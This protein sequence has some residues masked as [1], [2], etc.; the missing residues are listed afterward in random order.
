MALYPLQ[1]KPMDCERA[2]VVLEKKPLD[3]KSA[4]LH[5]LLSLLTSLVSR[6]EFMHK[7]CK[8]N[9]PKESMAFFC[10]QVS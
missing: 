7:K 9:P 3:A 2:T 8:N 4:G 10:G 5:L 1:L 6:L